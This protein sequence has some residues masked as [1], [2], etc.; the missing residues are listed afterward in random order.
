MSLFGERDYKAEMRSLQFHTSQNNMQNGKK[1][2]SKVHEKRDML[3]MSISTKILLGG[4]I[5]LSGKAG[6]K[7]YTF[8][9]TDSFSE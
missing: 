7:D 4:C 6:K 8:C 5:S 3:L 9:L 2:G 1:L